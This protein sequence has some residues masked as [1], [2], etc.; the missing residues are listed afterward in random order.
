MRKSTQAL[1]VFT[2]AA[3]LACNVSLANSSSEKSIS[4]TLSEKSGSRA[5]D[6]NSKVV[7][8]FLFCTAACTGLRRLETGS[9]Y[10]ANT[11]P[12]LCQYSA[13][14]LPILCQYSA[15][16]LPILCQYSANTPPILRQYSANTLPILCYT[17][18]RYQRYCCLRCRTT[19]SISGNITECRMRKIIFPPALV[20]SICSVRETARVGTGLFGKTAAP[21]SVKIMKRSTRNSACPAPQG[22]TPSV[23]AVRS[24]DRRSV[25][26]IGRG[27][28][29]RERSTSM[30]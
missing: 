14:T 3:T 27:E 7:S 10:S 28:F 2:R 11:L 17:T 5:I 29:G 23:I 24:A 12:I 22:K 16:T 6:I 15:N 30:L 13:N 19:L 8:T 18:L 20:V 9:Q 21:G 1:C 25:C 4:V 26:S